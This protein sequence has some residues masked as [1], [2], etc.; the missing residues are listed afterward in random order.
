M[1]DGTVLVTGAGGFLGRELVGQLVAAGAHVRCL[2]HRPDRWRAPEGVELAYGDVTDAGDVKRAVAGARQVYHLAGRVARESGQ[3]SDLFRLHVEGTR[4]VCREAAGAGVSK[5][6]LVSSSGTIAV[7]GGPRAQ[8][9]EAGC[10]PDIFG[11]W[12][13]YTSKMYAEKLALR[14]SAE[15]GVPVVVAGPALVL[16]PGD[17]HES[18]TGDV[19]RALDGG[20]QAAPRGG[21]N[22]V[23]VRDVAAGLIAAMERGQPGQR[24]LLG[25]ENWTFRRFFGEIA[26]LAGRTAPRLSVPPTLANALA[27]VLEGVRRR[28]AGLDPA[29]IRMASLYWYVDSSKAK[30]DLGWVT[31]PGI[32]TLRDTIADL[33]R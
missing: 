25:G 8:D 32:D 12:P 23:D 9:E 6:V 5:L 10:K 20:I 30:R 2:L 21:L 33:L 7:S 17:V 11:D 27:R 26:R 29:S 3:D 13:Y 24:Y 18:S 19:A 15:G 4:I 14:Q 22:F 1:S 28:P 16:G 31:R